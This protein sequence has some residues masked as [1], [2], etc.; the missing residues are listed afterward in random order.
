[1]WEDDCSHG[2]VC[3]KVREE[4]D[5]VCGTK[6]GTSGKSSSSHQWCVPALP[7]LFEMPATPESSAPLSEAAVTVSPPA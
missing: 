3:L 2:S 7:N 6:A 4:Q 1:M 5:A